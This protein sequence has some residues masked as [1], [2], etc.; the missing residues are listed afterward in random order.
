MFLM[1]ITLIKDSIHFYLHTSAYREAIFTIQLGLCCCR[2]E[3]KASQFKQRRMGDPACVQ[4]PSLRLQQEHIH[5]TI[6]HCGSTAKSSLWGCEERKY[7]QNWK[8]GG[9][10]ACRS[11]TVQSRITV[12][13]CVGLICGKTNTSRGLKPPFMWDVSWLLK[14]PC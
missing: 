2:L 5:L 9:V 6:H 4:Q 10:G 8:C 3:T 7:S 14:K 11:T 12:A 1:T 13:A